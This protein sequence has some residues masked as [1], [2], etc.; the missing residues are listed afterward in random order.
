M[1]DRPDGGGFSVAPQ[2]L[3]GPPGSRRAGR[4]R[5]AIASIGVGA[6]TILAIS[7]LGPRLASRPSPDGVST[8]TQ[9]PTLSLPPVVAFATPLPAL[10]GDV[11]RFSGTVGVTSDVFRVLDLGTGETIASY[12]AVFNQDAVVP[13]PGGAG[14]LCIC[15]AGGS[16]QDVQLVHL[17][18]RGHEVGR[19]IIGRL[20]TGSGPNR[21]ISIRT[22]FDFAADGR[23]GVLA[24]A[25]QGLSEWTYSI[26]SLDLDAGRLGPLVLLG[27]QRLDDEL[28]S[29][30][31]ALS[32]RI[33][34][35]PQVRLAPG[36]DRAFV[37][38]T[39]HVGAEP[40]GTDESL[41]WTVRL[42][43]LGNAATSEPVPGL[44]A[45]SICFVGGYL[46]PDQFVASCVRPEWSID[47]YAADGSLTR[48]LEMP[49]L[50][51]FGS[52][53]LFDT[54]NGAIWAWD[55][56][57]QNL[58]R[59]DDATDKVVSKTFDPDA[60][61]TSGGENL[62]GEPP[63]WI[64]P[65]AMAPLPGPGS[66]QMA[67]SPDG[68]RL[69]LLAYAIEPGP[70]GR[71][72]VNF[73]ILVVD[74]R[75]MALLDRWAADAAYISIDVGLEGAVVMASGFAGITD[76]G[77]SSLWEAS[78]TFHDAADG[79]ILARYGRLGEEGMATIIQP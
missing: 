31:P 9:V 49:D 40:T 15:M 38:A 60:K 20:G 78:V 66:H 8:E 43:K 16:V 30:A 10:T 75:T 41:G 5:L 71:P 34:V 64:R 19:E 51:A 26:A 17:D 47:T 62:G 22:A 28:S 42:D 25:V 1:K 59:I 23:T 53:M 52:D 58:S 57:A 77:E 21:S 18:P 7:S 4:R 54:A 2:P 55:G 74:P 39:L 63:V 27:E 6:A 67:G 48:R 44:A 32:Q 24:V 76:R 12:P 37:W 13:A 56:M 50:V 36:G 3:G 70:I 45:D 61:T 11:G 33:L 72:P 68:T 65:D 35:G 29:P 46:A 14:W 79:R 69:Y 73:G